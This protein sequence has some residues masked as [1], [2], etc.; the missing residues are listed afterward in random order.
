[1]LVK[2]A[3]AEFQTT[4]QAAARFKKETT[5]LYRLD[6]SQISREVWTDTADCVYLL[7][8]Q[9]S[10]TYNLIQER[11][12]QLGSSID[13]GQREIFAGEVDELTAQQQLQQA[14]KGQLCELVGQSLDCYGERLGYLRNASNLESE[15]ELLEKDYVHQRKSLLLPLADIGR[16]DKAFSLAERHYAFDTLTQL[17]TSLPDTQQKQRLHFYLHKYGEPYSQALFSF[18]VEHGQMQTLLAQ[19]EE[20]SGL[21]QSY[22]DAHPALNRVAWLHNLAIHRS[23]EASANLLREAGEEKDSTA[24]KKLMLSIAKLSHVS[25]L[26]EA[27]IA[28]QKEQARVELIDDQLDILSV[29]E[30]IR[31]SIDHE[32]PETTVSALGEERPALKD[33][34]YALLFGRGLA[35]FSVAVPFAYARVRETTATAKRRSP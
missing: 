33:V 23:D 6:D 16:L 32:A 17:C 30:R 12:R 1:M 34:S 35:N 22:L 2:G 18:Y 19:D 26:T 13:M 27:E 15:H 7:Q 20:F 8:S 14:L 21:L 24:S 28:T 10:L 11:H 5:D 9:A 3:N 4:F 29:Q 31:Q 25:Q